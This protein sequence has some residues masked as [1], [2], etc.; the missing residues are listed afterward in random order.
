VYKRTWHWSIST[1]REDEPAVLSL[2][3]LAAGSRASAQEAGRRY[4]TNEWLLIGWEEAGQIVGCVG[5]SREDEHSLELRSVAV[6]NE[7]QGRG[8]G[9]AL[10]E[11]LAEVADQAALVAETDEDGVGFYR[12]CGF[13][14][15]AAAPKAGR[16]RFRCVRAP[17]ARLLPRAQRG[18]TLGEIE[19]AIRRSE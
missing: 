8:V 13:E 19:Q 1:G 9:R 11:A 2:L 16:A 4:A 7:W 15:E 3:Q 6:P 18:I 10:I 17:V 5:L 14:V 12:S